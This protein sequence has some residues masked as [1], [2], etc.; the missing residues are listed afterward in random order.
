MTDG[1]V[2]VATN[3][4]YFAAR[5]LDRLLASGRPV[6]VVLTRSLQRGRGWRLARRWGLRYAAFKVLVNAVPPLLERVTRRPVTVA[7]LCRAYRVPV[8]SC[9]DLNSQ[10]GQALLRRLQPDVLL[11]VSCPYLLNDDVL[12]IASIGNMNVH[13]SLLPAYAGVSTYVHVLAEGEPVTG[14][15]LHEM[16]PAADAGQVLK[17]AAVPITAGLSAFELFRRQCEAAAPLVSEAVEEA[18]AR[19]AL[20]GTAQDLSSRSYF[21]DPTAADIKRLRRRGHALVRVAELLRLVRT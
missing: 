7:G 18:V 21:R 8:E 5:A 17:Q 19:G 13:S 9:A 12:S 3:G 6:V 20:H 16:V 15:T 10:E 11:S 4:N 2:V 14:V 1:R